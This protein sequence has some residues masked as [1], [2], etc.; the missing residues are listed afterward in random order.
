MTPLR[1]TPSYEGSCPQSLACYPCHGV[2]LLTGGFDAKC[3]VR[4]SPSIFCP[5]S[6]QTTLS[7]PT[8][9][10]HLE[11]A[12]AT[13]LVGRVVGLPLGGRVGG[14][15]VIAR[16]LTPGFCLGVSGFPIGPLWVAPFNGLLKTGL[17]IRFDVG[18]RS[19]CRFA[20]AVGH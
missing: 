7:S 16:G 20:F 14:H 18:T 1:L 19:G 12:C 6:H 3:S 17:V 9:P 11:A 8:M 13:A 10:C 2:W 5:R 15:L 4:F